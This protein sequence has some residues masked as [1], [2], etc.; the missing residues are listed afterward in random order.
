MTFVVSNE[1]PFDV[2][3]YVGNALYFI[4]AGTSNILIKSDLSNPPLYVKR[5]V[6]IPPPDYKKMLLLEMFGFPAALFMK[7]ITYTF[8]V[9]AE[10]AYAGE[11]S[12][13]VSLRIGR[14]VI[15]AAVEGVYD[16]V[17]LSSPQLRLFVRHYRVENQAE[18]NQTY[19]KVRRTAHLWLYLLLEF[20]F[21]LIGMSLVFPL[22][23]LIYST[24]EILLFKILL[25]VTPFLIIGGIALVGILPMHFMF[26][27]QDDRFYRAMENNEIRSRFLL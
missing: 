4:G 3:L 12:D 15:N 27:Y 6:P 14:L 7:P 9:S 1:N 24:T 13:N 16:T 26:K 20:L 2:H 8:D 22:L 5:A 19:Q 11:A 23:L 10:Y 21:T 17:S 25:Y 18:I